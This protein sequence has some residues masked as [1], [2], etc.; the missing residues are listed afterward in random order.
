MADRFLAGSHPD[1]QPRFAC[2]GQ[3]QF[4][5]PQVGTGR[6]SAALRP[7]PDEAAA[8]AALDA[9]GAVDVKELRR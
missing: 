6:L 1:G 3:A 2:I 7:F 8:R 5:E 4:T 9:A